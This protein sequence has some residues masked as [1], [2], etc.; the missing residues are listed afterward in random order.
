MR[1]ELLNNQCICY[2]RN[3]L[4]ACPGADANELSELSPVL[5]ATSYTGP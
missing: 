5:V 1:G 4:Q 3:V 2:L